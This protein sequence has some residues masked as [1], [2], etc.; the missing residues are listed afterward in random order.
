MPVYNGEEFIADAIRSV[1][2]QTYTNWEMTIGNNWSK[3]RTLAIA[4]EFASQDPR[5][6]V[7]TYPKFVSVVESHNNA[8]ALVSPEAKYCKLLSADD[9]LFPECIEE[10]VKVAEQHPTV[11]MV[12]SYVLAGS[13]ICSGFPYP[14]TFMSGRE[15]VRRRFTSDLSPLGGPSQSLIRASIIREKKPFYNPVNYHGDIEAYL[16]LL[17]DHD[18]GF[19]HQI[20]TYMRTGEASR[21][22]SYLGRVQSREAAPMDELTKYGRI[23]LTEEEFTERLRDATRAYYRFLGS[24]VWEFRPREFWDYHLKHV[25]AL[26]YPPNYARIAGF[27]V[28]RLLEMAGNPLRTVQGAARRVTERRAR[29]RAAAAAQ[30]HGPAPTASSHGPAPSARASAV[31]H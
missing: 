7:V 15:V 18:L 12:V 31:T 11:G 22:T 19:V 2:A 13:K 6:R 1:L 29:R 23:Y 16:D 17:Q 21:T 14:V 5:I 8:F 10:M 20:L 3:D 28:L 30:S 25:K 26:G 4:E 27:A 24:N 9:L